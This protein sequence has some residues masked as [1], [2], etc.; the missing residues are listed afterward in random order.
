MKLGQLSLHPELIF[1]AT[2]ISE[3]Y[4]CY[5]QQSSECGEQSQI[6]YGNINKSIQILLETSS[7]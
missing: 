6:K 2:H 5:S 3:K 4:L 7:Y 1:K